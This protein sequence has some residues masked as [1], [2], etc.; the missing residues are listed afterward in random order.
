MDSSTVADL[1]PTSL[2]ALGLDE[3]WLEHWVQEDP[4][5]LSLGPNIRIVHAQLHKPAGS[6]RASLDVQ[7]VD[8]AIEDRVYDVEL[9]RGEV[10]ADHGFRVLDYWAREQAEDDEGR[11]HRPVIVAERILGTRY[12]TVLRTL[13]DRLGLIA[14]E[15]RG[16]LVDGKPAVRIEPVVVPED[17]QPTGTGV[18]PARRPLSEEEWKGKT[19]EAFQTFLREF[20]AR[21][22]SWGLKHDLRWDAKS[23]I[24]LWKGSRCWCPIWP[25]KEAGARLYL[26]APEEWGEGGESP[27]AGFEEAH[28]QLDRE[29]IKLVWAWNYNA[30]ANPVAVTLQATHLDLPLV[31]TLLESSWKACRRIA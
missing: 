17:L 22:N 3:A 14:L 6:G 8:E 12:T 7:A 4:K 1:N 2:Q 15:V 11:E 28:R 23:Y 26:P 16:Y 18:G 20:L 25:R 13:A 19:T 27:P 21:V 29:G 30:G 24:G 10:D 9:M 5:R 31:R